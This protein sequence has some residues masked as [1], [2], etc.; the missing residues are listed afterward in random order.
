MTP[1]AL[2]DQRGEAIGLV[3][4]I[5]GGVRGLNLSQT[6]AGLRQ[7][8]IAVGATPSWGVGWGI[9]ASVGYA[10]PAK[11]DPNGLGSWVALRTRI[12]Q[13][14]AGE[15]LLIPDVGGGFFYGQ[16]RVDGQGTSLGAASLTSTYALSS[17]AYQRYDLDGV[18]DVGLA[19]DGPL[20]THIRA[21]LAYSLVNQ[22]LRFG[23]DPDRN[24]S[25]D[26]NLRTQYYGG[27]IGLFF[28]GDLPGRWQTEFGLETDLLAASSRLGSTQNFDG[29]PLSAM[30]SSLDFAARIRGKLGFTYFMNLAKRD[31]PV[32]EA[33]LLG[34]NAS[35]EWSSFVPTVAHPLDD[36]APGTSNPV[37]VAG[38]HSWTLGGDVSLGF[39]F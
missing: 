1:A 36:P 35:A 39:L 25:I 23:S 37:R 28:Q 18:Y 31:L 6:Q 9:D 30:D 4:E 10:L 5:S 17:Y 26:E 8:G 22:R 38:G 16:G 34:A 2:A 15:R 12:T 20:S 11:F 13:V 24:F 19:S 21:G 7:P 27:L 33:L 3:A 32:I 29:T 14:N